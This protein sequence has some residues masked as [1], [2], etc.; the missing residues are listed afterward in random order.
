MHVTIM[1]INYIGPFPI[2]SRIEMA[3]ATG[4]QA[5]ITRPGRRMWPIIAA[6]VI[7]VIAVVGVFA[8]VYLLKP[9]SSN[10]V[11]DPTKEGSCT[12]TVSGAGA[13]FPYFVWLNWTKTYEGL[14]PNVT[15]NYASIGST[16]GKKVIANQTQ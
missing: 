8:Y 6:A 9:S 7:I 1:T 15:V 10:F 11:C 12:V 4:T 16:A 5:P 14:Y 2:P 13:S 3:T